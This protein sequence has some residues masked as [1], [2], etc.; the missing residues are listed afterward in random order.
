MKFLIIG[1]G[2]I[3][4]RHF[5][6]LINL[7]YTDFLFCR[8]NSEEFSEAPHIPVYKD[9]D[10][11]LAQK[12]DLVLV[13][14]PSSMHLEVAIPAAKAGCNLFIE[15]PLSNQLNNIENLIRIVKDN[16]TTAM[17]GFDLRFDPGLRF[18]KELLDSQVFGRILSVQAEVGQY[19]PDWRKDTDYR[20]SVT[21]QSK[22]GGGVI[23]ELIHEFDYVQ[24]LAG[25]V[26]SISCMSDTVSDLEIDVEDIAICILKFVNGAF[27]TLNLD[28]LQHKASR[29]C[30]IVCEKSTIYWDYFAQSVRWLDMS[31]DSW[32]SFRYSE[33]DRNARFVSEMKH[34]IQC[35][36]GI[37]SP[38]V[39]LK[40]AFDVLRVALAA[41]ES[42]KTHRT[43]DVHQ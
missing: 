23:L 18:V 20:E 19:L 6:N 21:A 10:A 25:P 13:C 40:T 7:G 33:S 32:K 9:I 8:H 1:L 43:I 12:P 26:A 22:L 28:C 15:K 17:V 5:T 41:K 39:D 42:A 30:K 24:W 35:V 3:G 34:C 2:S 4:K 38:V 36:Q 11:A 31:S 27:G 16:N 29:N 37:E 14:N